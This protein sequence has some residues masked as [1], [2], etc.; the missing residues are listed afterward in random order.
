MIGAWVV[1]FCR[2][3]DATPTTSRCAASPFLLVDVHDFGRGLE[4][5]LLFSSTWE[6]FP[7]LHW[8]SSCLSLFIQNEAQIEAQ[9]E[10]QCVRLISQV[11]IHGHK[12]GSV[13]RCKDRPK[14]IFYPIQAILHALQMIVRHLCSDRMH[15]D[16]LVPH[17]LYW[18]SVAP[19][20]LC[21]RHQTSRSQTDNLVVAIEYRRSSGLTS[22]FEIVVV[23]DFIGVKIGFKT[24]GN[25]VCIDVKLSRTIL[26]ANN[27]PLSMKRVLEEDYFSSHAGHTSPLIRHILEK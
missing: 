22:G 2:R 26:W 7:C 25:G 5:G 9:I 15:G 14:I 16:Q 3:E 13:K 18:T 17:Q 27:V 21:L 19:R 11:R 4:R 12:T 20:A 8:E 10:V 6:N 24:R 23:M 1:R